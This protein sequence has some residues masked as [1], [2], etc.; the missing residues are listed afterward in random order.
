[1]GDIE[2]AIVEFRTTLTYCPNNLV[3]H[4]GLGTL[5][6]DERRNRDRAV[7][8]FEALLELEPGFSRAVEVRERLLEL[9][10]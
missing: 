5:Y 6:A 1:L 2:D 3:A 4:Y 7:F 9:T 10:W 8:H